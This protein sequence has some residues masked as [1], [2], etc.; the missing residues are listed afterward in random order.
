LRT[1][2]FSAAGS[3]ATACS[4]RRARSAAPLCRLAA[5]QRGTGIAVQF[6]LQ[7]LDLR[8]GFGEMALQRRA[9]T[10]RLAGRA[11][12]HP[13]A[14]LRHRVQRDRAGMTQRG[15]AADQRLVE[16]CR[17]GQAGVRQAV[18]IDADAAAQPLIWQLA[19]AQAGQFTRTADAVDAGVEPQRD[20]QFGVG[21]R[22]AGHAFAGADRVIQRSEVEPADE[23]LNRAHRVLGRQQLVERA[24]T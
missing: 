10:E 14:I 2:R 11:G 21:W 15:D 16:P 19:L 12:P 6:L 13:Q 5:R 9:A 22:M 17:A 23:R 18:V 3:I 20:H 24:G 4:S 8:L 1:A 7:R